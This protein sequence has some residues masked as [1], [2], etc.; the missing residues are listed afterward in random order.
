MKDIFLTFMYDTVHSTIEKNEKDG[1]FGSDRGG[2]RRVQGFGGKT[3]GTG[4][5]LKTQA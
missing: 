2:E 5:T 1:A 3:R 4:T